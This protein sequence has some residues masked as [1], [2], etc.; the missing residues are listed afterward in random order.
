MA[1]APAPVDDADRHVR[2]CVRAG[3]D[4]LALGVEGKA[5]GG[6]GPVDPIAGD[7]DAVLTRDRDELARREGHA[8]GQLQ[9]PES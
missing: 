4:D 7:F 5:V 9:L 3:L 1:T 8:P 6:A 2:E